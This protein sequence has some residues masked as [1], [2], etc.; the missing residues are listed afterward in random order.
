MPIACLCHDNTR[1]SPMYTTATLGFWPYNIKTTPVTGKE[2]NTMYHDHIDIDAYCKRVS[3]TG[4]RSASIDT[5]AAL[6]RAHTQ[7]IPFENLDPFH[8]FRVSLDTDDLQNKL[9]RQQRGGYCYEH[10]L[11]F[12][13]VLQ[14]LGFNVHRL[15]ARVLV[16][17]TAQLPPK[18]HMLLYVTIDHIPYLVDVGFGGHSPTAPL[19]LHASGVQQTP[20]GAYEILQTN[21][22]Y[23]LN[24]VPDD[25]PTPL[26]Q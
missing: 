12:S 26:Y 18:T 20:H 8:G 13:Y 15:A 5:L 6:Q 24:A 23:Q 21:G 9:V 19:R 16:S 22:S 3:Y 25:Q 1:P 7:T 14:N 4:S 11:L 2:G 10:N 17:A